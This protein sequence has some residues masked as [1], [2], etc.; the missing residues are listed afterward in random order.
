MLKHSEAVTF[1]LP[2][3]THRT[4][5]GG[6]E[7]VRTLEVWMQTLAP[8]A[9]TPTHRHGCEEVIVVL[10]GAGECT[11]D[12][13]CIGFEAGSTLIIPMAAVH[14]I[15]NTS[16]ENMNLIAAMGASPVLVRT[17]D[18]ERMPL[19]WDRP[20]THKNAREVGYAMAN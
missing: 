10:S 5:A 2:G 9:V 18:G 13:R 12:D 1:H 8:G 7:G 4:L 6:S 14:Q 15:V 19:P 17:A 11:I 16:M 3:L 20:T